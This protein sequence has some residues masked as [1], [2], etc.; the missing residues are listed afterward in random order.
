MTT[1]KSQQSTG[2]KFNHPHM[3]IPSEDTTWAVEQKPCVLRFWQQCWLADPFGS[4]WMKLMT[5]LSDSAFRLARRV[6]EAASLFVFRRISCGSDGRTSVWE[7][8]NLHGARV[9]D[10]WQG[11]KNEANT[12]SNKAD[13]ISKQAFTAIN[14]PD[15]VIQNQ[16][17]Q[18]FCEPSRTPQQHLTNSSKEFV[19]CDSSAPNEAAIAHSGCA[20]PS[21][22]A[23]ENVE[24]PAAIDEKWSSEAL[25]T[26]DAIAARSK[27]RPIRMKK[28]KMAHLLAENPGF[29]F[30]L[31]CWEDDPAMRF[32]IKQLLLKFPQ[33]G[34]VCVDGELVNCNN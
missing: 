2:S 17:D 5:N 21:T 4:R 28:L 6:L 15:T 23:Q 8:K 19:R 33:W 32:V 12:A 1:T 30:L 27:S 9:K 16:S 11:E 10:F 22:V 3:I 14:E 13:N 24:L 20:S 7:V 31:S 34:I 25:F 18:A 26:N 29:D